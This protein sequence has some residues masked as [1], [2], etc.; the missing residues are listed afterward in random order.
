MIFYFSV[1]KIFIN[2]TQIAGAFEKLVFCSFALEYINWGA[3]V[4]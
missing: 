4:M 2:S 1:F 3:G